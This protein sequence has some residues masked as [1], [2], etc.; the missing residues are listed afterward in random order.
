MLLADFDAWRKSQDAA[1]CK[2]PLSNFTNGNDWHEQFV[3]YMNLNSVGQ[4]MQDIVT[5]LAWQIYMLQA[6]NEGLIED[7]E[8]LQNQLGD[9]DHMLSDHDD[10]LDE[11]EDRL[12]E[13][14]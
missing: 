2:S 14:G 13:L 3:L 11:H 1:R 6:C 12:D 9:V 8:E 4:N 5:D 7:M 10:I